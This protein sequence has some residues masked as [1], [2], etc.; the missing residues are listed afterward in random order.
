MALIQRFHEIEPGN[1]Q[2]FFNELIG[3]DQDSFFK[4]H[5]MKAPLHIKGAFRKEALHFTKENFLEAAQKAQYLRLGSVEKMSQV[6]NIAEAGTLLNERSVA[7]LN[8][9]QVPEANQ[10]QAF[11]DIVKTYGLLGH[12]LGFNLSH[13]QHF[14]CSIFLSEEKSCLGGHYDSGDAF[15]FNL[16]GRKKWLVEKRPNFRR[17][18]SHG[19]KGYPDRDIQFEDTPNE[20]IVEPGDCLYL[21]AWCLHRVE[22]IGTS[23]GLTFGYRTISEIDLLKQVLARTIGDWEFEYEPLTSYPPFT[24]ALH[25]RSKQNT[26]DKVREL[27]KRLADTLKDI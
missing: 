17:A 6:E 4:N 9:I 15:N 11:K 1:I 10:T 12:H 8:L 19:I 26:K 14:V 23:M 16:L 7:M 2:D 22:G 20:Y 13:V 27:A 25:E 21:P 3:K 5:W 18:A 24:G